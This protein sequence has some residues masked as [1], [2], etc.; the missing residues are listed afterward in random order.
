M[1]VEP[2]ATQAR[3]DAADLSS[4]ERARMLIA[5]KFSEDERAHESINCG[6]FWS[7]AVAQTWNAIPGSRIF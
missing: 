5:S 1:Q 4:L 3:V 2:G 6:K 7:S